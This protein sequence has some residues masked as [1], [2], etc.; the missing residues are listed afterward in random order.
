MNKTQLIESLELG[1]NAASYTPGNV[2]PE[3]MKE[4]FKDV[5]ESVKVYARKAR[6]EMG[7]RIY[8]VDQTRGYCQPRARVLTIPLW[9]I[10]RSVQEK[11]WYI[12]HELAHAFDKCIHNHGPE[13]MEWLKQICPPDCIHYELGYKPRNAASAGIGQPKKQDPC[14]WLEL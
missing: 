8:V 14:D 11:T 1:V 9:V 10:S 7:Y 2:S 6:D 12:A 3:G 13:F 4:L 5:P